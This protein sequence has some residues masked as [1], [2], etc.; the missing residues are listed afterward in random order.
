MSIPK[1]PAGVPAPDL[2]VVHLRVRDNE[3]VGRELEVL[4]GVEARRLERRIAGGVVGRQHDATALHGSRSGG[5]VGKDGDHAARELSDDVVA[6]RLLRCRPSARER[7]ANNECRDQQENG[8]VCSAQLPQHR[9]DSTV[10]MRMQSN[11]ALMFGGRCAQP[12]Y[13]THH[14]ADGAHK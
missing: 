2:H 5:A 10:R 12:P 14:P 3:V 1:M 7:R 9:L 13:T 4:Q 11:D 6:Q 8:G